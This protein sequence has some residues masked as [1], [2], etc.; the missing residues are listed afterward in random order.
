MHPRM[1]GLLLCTLPA[2]AL[3]GDLI[4]RTVPPYPDGLHDVGGSCLTDTPGYE[5]ICDYSIGVLADGAEEGAALRWIVLGRMAGREGQQARWLITDAVA[6]PDT[7]AGYHLQTGTCRLDGKE[8]D[9]VLA[10]V[11]DDPQGELLTDVVWAR[12]VQLP[13]ARFLPIEPARVDCLNEAAL[14]L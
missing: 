12:R 5:H 14:G 4:G 10:V 6:H 8:D 7:G 1:A 9:R 2:G 13:Q 3:A 11:R